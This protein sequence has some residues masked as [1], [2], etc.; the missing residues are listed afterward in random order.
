MQR[1]FSTFPDGA[2]GLGL[3]LLRVAVAA[4][5][6]VHTV[7]CLAERSHV[8]LGAWAVVAL[9]AVGGV[10]LLTGLL[11][12]LGSAIAALAAGGLTLSFLPAPAGNVFEAR[13][14]AVVVVLAAVAI[15]LIGPGAFSLDAAL[16]GRREITIPPR[17]D[18]PSRD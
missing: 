18:K 6:A 10:S 13:L 11:T 8:T 7:T 17:C 16:F 5:L 3:L 9:A 12:P 4:A 1:L 14:T 15:G 2:P